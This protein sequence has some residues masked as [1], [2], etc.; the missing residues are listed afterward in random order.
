MYLYTVAFGLASVYH[1]VY[2]C[3]N[4]QN[5]TGVGDTI[6]IGPESR[7]QSA[8]YR[9]RNQILHIPGSQYQSRYRIYLFLDTPLKMGDI[10]NFYLIPLLRSWYWIFRLSGT[11]VNK[12][13]HFFKFYLILLAK[14]CFQYRLRYQY[15]KKGLDDSDTVS[16]PRDGQKSIP[17]MILIP[18]LCKWY[19]VK[20]EELSQFIEWGTRK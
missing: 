1:V 3:S 16:G 12:L 4:C 6:G 9:Y 5:T 11:P 14:S 7:Y 20:F 18:R 19:K 15:Q 2:H 10:F 17:I 8:W 13:G